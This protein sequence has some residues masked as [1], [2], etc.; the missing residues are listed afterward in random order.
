MNTFTYGLNI[1]QMTAVRLRRLASKI[2]CD[3][4]KRQCSDVNFYSIY[5]YYIS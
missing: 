3:G 2:H 1:A 4:Q 5:Y